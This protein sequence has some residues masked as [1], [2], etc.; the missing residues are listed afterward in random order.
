MVFQS[1]MAFHTTE[2]VVKIDV[3]RKEMGDHQVQV[4]GLDFKFPIAALKHLNH[5]KELKRSRRLLSSVDDI[6]QPFA[7][8]IGAA[9]CWL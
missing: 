3:V 9:V 6:P 4:S 2:T 5:N 8:I 1:I 7:A